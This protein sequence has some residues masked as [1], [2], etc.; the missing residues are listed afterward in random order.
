M[1]MDAGHDDTLNFIEI[2]KQAKAR[3]RE[4][5]FIINARRINWKKSADK[6]QSEAQKDTHGNSAFNV[7]CSA[8]N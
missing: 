3:D 2:N 8:F 5:A 6:T 1:R 7:F 4:I